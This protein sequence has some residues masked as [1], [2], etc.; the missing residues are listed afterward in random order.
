MKKF[1]I[2]TAALA[3]MASASCVKETIAPE[4]V[5]GDG[6][7]FIASREDFGATTKTVLVDGHKVEWKAN[8]QVL[9]FGKGVGFDKDDKATDS[10]TFDTEAWKSAKWF[11]TSTGG[12]SVR[13]VCTEPEYQ[14]DP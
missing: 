3:L 8:N 1:T 7:S 4:T 9:V 14:F 5:E 13:F 10:E 11:T 2:F 6:V 12:A